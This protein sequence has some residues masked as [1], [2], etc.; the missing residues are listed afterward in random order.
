MC[1][2]TA[3]RFVSTAASCLL[4]VSVCVRVLCLR[5]CVC[6]HVV[7]DRT[8]SFRSRVLPP[9]SVWM[10]DA[11]VKGL[12]ICHPQVRAGQGSNERV[13]RKVTLVQIARNASYSQKSINT[14]SEN[15]AKSRNA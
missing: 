6:V 2:A 8:V 3:G 1:V 12:E 13:G 9:K 14:R 15:N 4:S 7:P 11:K 10:E 5:V